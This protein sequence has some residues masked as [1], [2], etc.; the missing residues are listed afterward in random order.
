M[1]RDPIEDDPK[2]KTI[3]ESVN[4]QV[5]RELIEMGIKD[6]W[7]SCFTYW[8]IKKRILLSVHGID[9]KT[10]RELNPRVVFD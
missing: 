3:I 5:E 7:G 8:D 9:W 4:E 10:P 1:K 2:F 6:Q